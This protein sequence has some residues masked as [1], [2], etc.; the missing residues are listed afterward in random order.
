M[1]LHLATSLGP[2]AAVCK[3][4]DVRGAE[5]VMAE[6]GR[7]GVPRIV[8]LST[9]TVYGPGPHRGT[10]VD[11]VPPA[12][13]PAVSG[14]RL[15]AEKYA[16]AAG[17]TVL[18]PGLV[19]GPG[20]RW[21]VPGGVELLRSVPA[22]WQGGRGLLS[23]T[24]VADLARLAKAALNALTLV[25]AAAVP[26]SVQVNAV[27]PGWVRTRMGG[28]QA[29]LS[30]EAGADTVTWLALSPDSGPSGGFYHERRLIPW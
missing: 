19:T 29:P 22:L 12:P 11:Q 17:A 25:V 5:A 14:S 23:M 28:S 27:C 21:V 4:V 3:A 6:A 24:D 16:L 2:D 30:A 15:A 18:R 13:V 26:P 20:D 9:A 1:L 10:G 7:A 8:H